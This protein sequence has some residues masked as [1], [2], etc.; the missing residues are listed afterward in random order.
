MANEQQVEASFWERLGDG[1]SAFTEGFGRFL[2]RLLGASNERYVKNLGY[3]RPNKPGVA[4]QVKPGS[5]LAQ[6]NELEDKMRGLTDEQLRELT[7]EFRRRLAN[8][9]TLEQLLPEAF[10]ACREAARRT[11]NMR[12]FDVQ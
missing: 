10:A 4:P 9:S 12:H 5:L 2:T 8:G 1:L 11:K 7:P 6:V 3:I